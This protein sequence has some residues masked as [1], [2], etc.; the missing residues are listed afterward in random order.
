[1][2]SF[3]EVV[4]LLPAA[5]SLST[6]AKSKH[7]RSPQ[8]HPG[9]SALWGFNVYFAPETDY[10]DLEKEQRKKILRER[11]QAE[12][13]RRLAEEATRQ[14]QKRVAMRL[15]YTKYLYFSAK[16]GP[17]PAL[18]YCSSEFPGRVYEVY[19]NRVATTL[20]HWAVRRME[21]LKRHARFYVARIAVDA[22]I[23]TGI[24][25]R[26]AV[27]SQHHHSQQLRA[28]V[29]FR[30]QYRIFAA[31]KA[32]TKQAKMVS[33]RFRR[34]M[35]S[36][37]ADRF[38]YWKEFVATRRMV[39]QGKLCQASIKVFHRALLNRFTWWRDVAA[40]TKTIKAHVARVRLRHINHHWHRWFA[41]ASFAKT[42]K[43]PAT[44][45]QRV[46]RGSR[47]RHSL[48]IHSRAAAK[49][50]ARMRGIFG[51]RVAAQRRE[52]LMT[53]MAKLRFKLR[54]ELVEQQSMQNKEIEAAIAAEAARRVLEKSAME[55]AGEEAKA[56]AMQALAKLL[57]NEYRAKL[58][59][60]I[61]RYKSE[62]GLNSK[63]ATARAT[64]EVIAEAQATAADDAR[65]EFRHAH[66]APPAS[67]PSCNEGL[68]FSSC[69]HV[70]G[71]SQGDRT[72]RLEAWNQARLND[73]VMALAQ[74]DARPISFAEV[75]AFQKQN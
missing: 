3:R 69:P 38:R 66:G 10:E 37:L 67:C 47:V 44:I 11:L 31:W 1:M 72:A 28:R 16:Y 5:T 59:D 68:P 71:E 65:Q 19:V 36:T 39:R 6:P 53:A 46:W 32:E 62:L 15:D 35:Q 26:V 43:L 50:Q 41:Y 4:D 51:R 48:Q 12:R 29:L 20:Q 17:L 27:L 34:A 45:I 18:L 13:E 55:L 54:K 60:K 56:E 57:G 49:I 25:R 58:K 64:Q 9:A 73:Q 2:T 63:Q 21:I 8:P 7:G 22:A 40:K 75:Y 30:A 14:E 23:A 70:C 61:A 42:Y 33:E 24:K 74:L 52:Q